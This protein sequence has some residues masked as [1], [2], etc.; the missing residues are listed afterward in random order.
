MK[1][2]HL[3]EKFLLVVKA[4]DLPSP[5][6]EHR[7]HPTR[8]WRLDFA[9]PELKVGVEINGGIWVNGGHSRGSGVTKDIEKSNEAKRLG[10]TIYTFTD[11]HLKDL[12][13][14][15]TYLSFLGSAFNA[16]GKPKNL[17]EVPPVK[18][19]K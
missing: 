4:L 2:S 1:K 7:F 9:W 16:K 13:Y 3:E 11:K 12:D 6:Q 8:R 10:W 5:E 15:N 14:I 17:H 19:P 18:K